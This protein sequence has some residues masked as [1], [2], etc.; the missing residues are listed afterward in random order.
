MN[1][2][3]KFL[4][5]IFITALFFATLRADDNS[6]KKAENFKLKDYNGKEYQL[7]DFKDS[8][9]IVIIFIATQCPVSNAYNSRMEKIYEEYKNKGVAFI[10]INSNKLES[11]EEVK[12][13]AKKNN[14]NFVILKDV[15]NVI[16]DKFKASVTPEV[17]VLNSEFDVLYHGRIDDSRKEEDVKSEDLRNA[18]NEILQ[19]K[20]VT[21]TETKAFGCTIKRVN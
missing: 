11:V 15:N 4:A 14:L 6:I 16:A 2:L 12:E 7:S 20:K 18:L 3:N 19:G 13:H 5:A 17:F 1:S 21:K 9:A 10:G 8:K